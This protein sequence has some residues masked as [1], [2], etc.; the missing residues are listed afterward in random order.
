[1]SA[2]GKAS[3]LL[4]RRSGQGLSRNSTDT[5]ISS[6]FDP[7]PDKPHNARPYSKRVITGT[8]GLE[9]RLGMPRLDR[10]GT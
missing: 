4:P 1:M 6:A 8:L 9:L 5:T 2:S 7:G 10:E 3:Q